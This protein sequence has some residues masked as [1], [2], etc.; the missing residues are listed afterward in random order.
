M[1]W[2][3]ETYLAFEAERTRPARELL[4]RIV[5]G[6]PLRVADLGCGPGNSTAL[7]A[8][9]WPG[10]ELWGIDSSP[11]MLTAARA[12]GVPARWCQ[13]DL[14]EW[15]AQIHYD[16]LFSNATLQWVADH[17]QLL[18]RLMRGLTKGG[19][20]ALQMPCNF[21]QPSHTLIRYVVEGKPWAR[22]FNGVRAATHVSS[23]DKYF[24]ILEP[25]AAAIDLWETTYV[26]VL[27]GEDAV[28]RWMTGTSLRP[29]VEALDEPQRTEFLEDYR[30]A[31]ARSYPRRTSGV[32]LFPFRR[33]FM[34][35]KAR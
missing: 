29:F 35:A 14:R 30:A 16:V 13:A 27:E 21:D 12:S 32:T 9:R 17:E 7:L 20:L 26:Q 6:H 10:A 25:H 2:D 8:A 4:A 19:T 28:F 22:F 1:T 11:E 3:P 18:P 23:P 31:L 33:L 34:V 5:V 15:S 24:E